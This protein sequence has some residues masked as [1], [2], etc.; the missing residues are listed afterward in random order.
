[1][2]HSCGSLLL[3]S[4]KVKPPEQAFRTRLPQ[5]SL[6]ESAKRVFRTRLPPKFTRQSS[7]TSDSYETSSKTH[8]SLISHVRTRLP[9]QVKCQSLKTSVGTRLPPKVRWKH[10]S[11]HTHQAALPSTFAI[12]APP[13]N[14]R[15]HANPNGTVTSTSTTTRHLTIPCACHEPFRFHNAHKV[16]R[17]PRNVTSITPRNLTIPCACHRACHEKSKNRIM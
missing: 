14:A 12:P 13:S 2:G 1:M 6:V 8:A 5:N 4:P 7:K 9:P 15:S 11:E 16:L 17:L 3:K 10:P